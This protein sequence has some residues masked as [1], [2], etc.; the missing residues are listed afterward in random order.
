MD[1]KASV[2]DGLGSGSLEQKVLGRG[3]ACL[4]HHYTQDLDECLP[5]KGCSVNAYWK[6]GQQILC[7]HAF[8]NSS[9]YY[10]TPRLQW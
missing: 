7:A 9:I 8:I 5:Q 2:W 3:P 1:Q 10:K 4:A 6:N